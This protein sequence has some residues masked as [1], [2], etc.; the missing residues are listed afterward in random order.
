MTRHFMG[1]PVFDAI[2]PDRTVFTI[3]WTKFN[4]SLMS[5][6]LADAYKRYV[7]WVNEKITVPARRLA[8]HPTC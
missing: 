7:E 3:N 2:Y 4:E 8:T 6:L 1:T 5:R